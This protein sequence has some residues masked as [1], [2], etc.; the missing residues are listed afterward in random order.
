MF[1]FLQTAVPLVRH[2][3]WQDDLLIFPKEIPLTMIISWLI[4]KGIYTLSKA[5]KLGTIPLV[6]NHEHSHPT[7]GKISLLM[8][9]R[10]GLTLRKS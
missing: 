2:F 6:R 9:K 8:L 1:F 7:D 4:L 5:A 10:C 3:L